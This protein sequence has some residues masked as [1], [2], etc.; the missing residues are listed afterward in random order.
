[1]AAATPEG[2][3][4]PNR[5][6][7]ED[8]VQQGELAAEEVAHGPPGWLP[9]LSHPRIGSNTAQQPSWNS[10]VY[11]LKKQSPI[12]RPTHN[13]SRAPALSCTARQPASMAAV[14]NK[15]DRGSMVMSTPPTDISG[16]AVMMSSRMNP[17]RALTSRA[18]NRRVIKLM[19]AAMTGAKNRTPKAVSPHK[20]VPRNCV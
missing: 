18:K 19:I 3:G 20:C 6:H 8:R 11:L 15:T 13:H 17:A 12:H 16:V 4:C 10:S 7:E 5:R 14:Q 2:D 9:G 1:M